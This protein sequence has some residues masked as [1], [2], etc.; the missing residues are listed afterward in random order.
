MPSRKK[1]KVYGRAFPISAKEV[2]AYE[3]VDRPRRR[4]VP[5]PIGVTRM[6]MVN[7]RGS[8]RQSARQVAAGKSKKQR[9]SRAKAVIRNG[10]GMAG[11]LKNRKTKSKSPQSVRAAA[12]RRVA[13]SR[14]S[15]NTT[16]R[17]SSSSTSRRKVPG[18][19]F[20]KTAN[21]R[22]QNSSGKYVKAT[23]VS[24]ARKRKSPAK[25]P[26]KR[27]TKS[28]APKRRVRR[29]ASVGA[30]RSYSKGYDAMK[31]SEA[32]KKAART[33]KRRAAAAARTRGKSASVGR[34]TRLTV[35]DP[36][37]GR[38]RRS[39]MYKTSKGKRRRIPAKAL[40]RSGHTTPAEIRRGRTKA[41][42]RVKK[43]GTAFVANKASSARRK[44]AGR[45]AAA[46]MAAKRRGASVGAAKKAAIRKVPLK[47]GDTFKGTTKVGTMRKGSRKTVATPKRRT[48]LVANKRRR[49]RK[50]TATPNRRRRTTT[51]RR[52]V[53]AKR[54]RA[55]PT[56][57]RRTSAKRRTSARRRKATP[58]RRRV[59]RRRKTAAKRRM[60]PNR[61]RRTYRRNQGWMGKFRKAFQSG[62]WIAGGFL[63]H[64]IVTNLI[65]DP[66][67][68]LFKRNEGEVSTSGFEMTLDQWKKPICGAGVLLIGIPLAGM[69]KR[70]TEL[71]AG[72]VVSWLHSVISS[73]ALASNQPEVIRAVG[74][75]PMRSDWTGRQWPY[76]SSRAYALHGRRRRRGVRGLGGRHTSSIMPRYAPVRSMQGTGQVYQAAAGQSWQQAA[77]GQYQQAAAG[78]YFG[79]QQGTGEYFAP[80]STQGIGAYEAAGQLAMPVDR[81]VITD[82][83]RPDTNLDDVM[84]TM[85]S[86]AGFGGGGVGSYFESSQGGQ[87]ERVGTQSQWIP[88][89]PM[90]AGEMKVN[91]TQETSELSAGILNRPGGNGILSGG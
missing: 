43:E 72:M 74:E 49:S 83:I 53:A 35:E 79:T 69:T 27:R 10:A 7:G 21:G 22:Y 64:K 12:A 36:R 57:R 61:R 45:R 20:Y 78:E 33:R 67:F 37:T 68:D 75:V 6:A 70:S 82:G 41:A 17:K 18:T 40:V 31:R 9:L 39:Y 3:R 25:S 1:S 32:A 60:S 42:R 48:K 26:A 5:N 13:K 62:M 81:S 44:R 38:K 91:A 56:R 73:L 71:G 88:Q 16:R 66:I 84:T 8:Y 52:K 58:N 54:R 29:N 4:M 76:P 23:T 30:S 63:G 90:W 46:Y 86:A 28:T 47:Q 15:K 50:K 34:Y 77:A 65:C 80:Q 51:R 59:T 19:N 87:M 89:G 2:K 14:T 11:F 85:E 24:A 55:T